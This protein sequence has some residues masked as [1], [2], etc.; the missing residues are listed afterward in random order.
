MLGAGHF[1]QGGP[2]LA[3]FLLPNMAQ[4]LAAKY[5]PFLAAKNGPGGHFWQGHLW[6][7]RSTIHCKD[8]KAKVIQLSG[9]KQKGKKNRESSQ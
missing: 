3:H 2:L 5:G 7:D 6:H 8:G 9:Y 1:W 4:R